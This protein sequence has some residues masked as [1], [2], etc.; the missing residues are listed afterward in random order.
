VVN[1]VP[2][3]EREIAMVFCKRA[4]YP[5]V[6]VAKHVVRADAGETVEGGD[7]GARCKAAAILGP[8]RT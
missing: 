6:T 8:S 2:P 7:L 1:R 3:K 5:H 4:L